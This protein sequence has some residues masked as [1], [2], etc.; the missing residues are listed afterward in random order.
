MMGGRAPQRWSVGSCSNPRVRVLRRCMRDVC[1]WRI[2]MYSL[3]WIGGNETLHLEYVFHS[4][5]F[6]P[7]R[8]RRFYANP[9]SMRL[10][11]EGRSE[12]DRGRRKAV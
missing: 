11:K 5:S 3:R 12:T 9:R 8:N 2:K 1:Q 10:S 7:M 4:D 6:R